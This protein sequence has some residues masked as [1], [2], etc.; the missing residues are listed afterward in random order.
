MTDEILPDDMPR[1][2]LQAVRY[3]A[4]LDLCR[5]YMRQIKWPDGQITCP[6][7][8]ATGDRIGQIET[9]HMMRC[10][11][12][13]K[14]FSHTVGTIFEDSKI[15][16][17]KW[18]VAVWAVANCKNGISSHELGRAIGVTQ[19][20]AWFML[21]RVRKAMECGS[22]AD[23]NQRFSGPT[24]ADTTYVGGEARN[25]HAAKRE[26]RI[27]G[28]GAVG[29]AIIHGVLQRASGEAVSQVRAEVVGTDD[30]ERL[31]PAVRRNVRFGAEVFTD[32]ARAYAELQ[33]TQIHRAIDHSIAYARGNV[34]TNGLENFWSL[35]KRGLRGTY[36][37][38]APFH[39]FRY[40]AEQVF[41][42]N[43]RDGGDADRFAA[44]MY[45]IVG[46]RLTYRLLTAQNDAG[47]MGLT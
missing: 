13:R 2:L 23:D 35:L 44:L 28:R 39:L 29:K 3:F 5:R 7:C 8:G 46:K 9:R 30:A 10:K 25:M 38:V 16:L 24:E 26:R 47:F 36:V 32:A 22:F 45:M 6:S 17:D 34:H 42:F 33:N 40:V 43:E 1:T 11:D 19:K 41:R 37:A 27:K 31:V 4:D 21:H 20:T 14:Q 15:S 12:C 18:F